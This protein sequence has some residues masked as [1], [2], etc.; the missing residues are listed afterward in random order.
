M[1]VESHFG[2]KETESATRELDPTERVIVN[3]LRRSCRSSVFCRISGCTSRGGRRNIRYSVL[4]RG[5]VVSKSKKINQISSECGM[6][7][8]GLYCS[9]RCSDDRTMMRFIRV[10]K[11]PARPRSECS[12]LCFLCLMMILE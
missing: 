7:A 9:K 11:T 2:L 3:R 4:D 10:A 12:S 6:L 8:G 5:Q 1:S